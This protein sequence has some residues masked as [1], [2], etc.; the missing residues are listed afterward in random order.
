MALRRLFVAN[1]GEIALRVVR[2]AQACNIETVLGVSAADVGSAASKLADR[3]VVLGPGPAARSYLDARLVVEVLDN[4]S[5]RIDTVGAPDNPV[6]ALFDW[7][8]GHS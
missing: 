3:T 4:D 6:V 7:S 5:L 2:A 1:R 8:E